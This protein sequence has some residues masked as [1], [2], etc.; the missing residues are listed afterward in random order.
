[1]VQMESVID[2]KN[3]EVSLQQ[4]WWLQKKL[5]ASKGTITQFINYKT[6]IVHKRT[7][8][9]VFSHM[10]QQNFFLLSFSSFFST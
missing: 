4:S 3:A 7:C 1:M 2:F 9:A 10:L 6:I 5:L 8:S